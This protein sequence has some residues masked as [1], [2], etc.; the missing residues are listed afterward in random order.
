MQPQPVSLVRPFSFAEG[1]EPLPILALR[2]F[3]ME[4][5]APLT[6]FAGDNAGETVC[7]VGIGKKLD[8]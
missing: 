8:P 5:H 6:A 7:R 3:S 1:E 2:P 4:L